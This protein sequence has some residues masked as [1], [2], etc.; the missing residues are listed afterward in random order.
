MLTQSDPG[1]HRARVRARRH[2]GARTTASRA[3]Q[4]ERGRPLPERGASSGSRSCARAS[5]RSRRRPRRSASTSPRGCP[6]VSTAGIG[7]VDELL[8]GQPTSACWSASSTRAAYEAAARGGARRSRRTRRRASAAAQVAREQLSLDEVGDTALRPAVPEVAGATMTDGHASA[9]SAPWARRRRRSGCARRSRARSWRA[10][11]SRCGTSRCSTSEQDRLLHGG[12]PAAA[13]ASRVAG[14]PRACGDELAAPTASSTWR[15]S[16]AR[17]TSCP[18]CALERLRGRRAPARARRGRR[19]LARRVA[20]G[21]RPPAGGAQGHAAEG[22]LAG[23]ARRHGDRR[24]RAARRV[25]RALRRATW[26]WSRRS[27][28]TASIPPRS[29]SRRERIVLGWIGSPSTAPS[30]E[31]LREPLARSLASARR[32]IESSCSS[33]GDRRR[34]SQGVQVRAERW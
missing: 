27:S 7:D 31:R 33:W 17:W 18:A 13:R 20:R 23:R 25:A 10:T 15:S 34:T 4:P 6:V 1:D 8:E 2:R 29:T 22:P 3:S 30:L 5:R 24:Q 16:S 19:D 21:R 14:P 11:A 26:S 28:S 12:S 9:P 32:T